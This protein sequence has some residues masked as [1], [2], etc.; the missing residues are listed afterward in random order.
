MNP[1]LRASVDQG[2][3]AAVLAAA[4]IALQQRLT[5]G[6]AAIGLA[7]GLGLV[8]AT[9]HFAA[10]R[11]WV[12]RPVVAFRLVVDFLRELTV[13]TLQVAATVMSPRLRIRPAFIVVPLAL[14]DDFAITILAN[15][16]TL[17][18]GTLTLDIAPDRSALYVHCLSV[19]DVEEVRARIRRLFERPIEE[20]VTCSISPLT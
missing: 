12:R 20:G 3:Y 5:I 18:P 4:W 15:M 11:I 10:G 17:T 16:I 9:R 8:R 6:D 7:L 2:L 14:A 19:D 1:R 13:S